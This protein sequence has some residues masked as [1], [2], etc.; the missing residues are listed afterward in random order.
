[1]VSARLG[2]A[3]DRIP[4][5]ALSWLNWVA[6]LGSVY[7]AVFALGAMLTGSP[8]RGLLYAAFSIGA[9]SLIYRNLRADDVL[10]SRVDT[11]GGSGLGLSQSR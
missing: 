2:F 4:G 9:F 6:G 7:S 8:G 11:G 3:G 1:R 5:G 10:N